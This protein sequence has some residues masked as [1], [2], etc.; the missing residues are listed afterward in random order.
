MKLNF[1]KAGALASL[2]M[3]FGSCSDDDNTETV[4]E[5]FASLTVSDQSLESSNTLNVAAVTMPDD[6]WIVVHRDN[7]SN[8]PVVPDIISEPKFVE[9]GV[10]TDVEVMLDAEADFNDGEK[11]WVML[12]NDSGIEGEYEF[13][14]TNGIDEPLMDEDGE[15]VMAAVM[16]SVEAEG[17]FTAQDQ[18]IEDNTV[19]VSSVTLNTDGWVVIHADDNGAPMVPDIISEPKYLEAGTYQDVEVFLKNSAGVEAGDTLWIMLHQDTGTDE[20]YEFDGENGLDTPITNDDGE[21]VTAPIEAL[22]VELTG[23]FEAADQTI[24]QN[25][26]LVQEVTMNN[27]G[28]VVIHKDNGNG[29]PMVP[30]IISVPKYVEAGSTADVKVQL[31]NTASITDGETL[32]VMLHTDNGVEGTYEFNGS[33]GLDGPILNDNGE[34]VTAPIVITAPSIIA[35]DQPVT[36][37]QVT[38]AEVHAATNGWI[39][40]HNQTSAGDIELPEIVGKAY[41]E[42]GSNFDVVIDLDS[43]VTYTSGQLLFPMLHID[44]APVEEY[45][46]PGVDVPEVFGFSSENTVVTSFVVQ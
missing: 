10:R 12:H 43:E 33:N 20:E 23:S 32:W 17:S 11:L 7:G 44:E 2:L 22:S 4:F 5:D 46:F 25:T 8:A 40:V 42:A 39:V 24:S 13:D 28:W 35:N 45:N 31:T 18:D 19:V 36:N 9:A 3:V 30:D 6:G 34:V 37:N 21:V 26:I 14:G 1:I 16:V 27:D 38:I 41:V 15:I 29:G